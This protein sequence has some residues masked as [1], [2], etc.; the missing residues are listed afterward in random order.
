MMRILIEVEVEKGS[1]QFR[2]KQEIGESLAEEVSNL[3][4]FDVDGSEYGIVTA[5]WYGEE[6][7]AAKRKARRVPA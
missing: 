4:E 1:G 2:S 3:S 5:F 7:P 6:E